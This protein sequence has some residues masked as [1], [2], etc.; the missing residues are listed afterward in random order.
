MAKSLIS[1]VL[2]DAGPVARL[3]PRFAL[4]NAVVPFFPE[5]VVH[6]PGASAAG[7]RFANGGRDFPARIGLRASDAKLRAAS[8]SVTGAA[9]ARVHFSAAC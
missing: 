8:R 5:V 9:R 4:K 1:K 7:V 3:G 2:Q 6:R